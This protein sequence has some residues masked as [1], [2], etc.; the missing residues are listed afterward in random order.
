MKG[1]VTS[2]DGASRYLIAWELLAA[3]LLFF[4]C[5]PTAAWAQSRCPPLDRVPAP[6]PILTSPEATLVPD[7]VCIPF[8]F[9][10]GF[11]GYGNGNPIAYFDQYSWRAFIALVWPSKN[12]SR[13]IPDPSQPLETVRSPG[14]AGETTPP[15]FETFKADWETFQPGGAGPS[16]W[17]SYEFVLTNHHEGCPLAKPGDFLLAP[18]NK[19][20]PTG[21]IKQAGLD[22]TT[23]VLVSRNGKFVRYQAAYN[24]KQFNKILNDKLF[25]ATNIEKD[26]HF[27]D[28]ALSV[29]SSWIDLTNIPNK[30]RYHKRLAWLPDP[31]NHTCDQV[32]VGLV[33]LHI[34]QKTRTRPQWIW[35]SFEHV[36]NVPPP[37]Y[38]P[39]ASQAQPTTFAFNDGTNARMPHDTPADYI[40]KNVLSAA[41]A[42]A[43][44]NIERLM[45]IN[46][47]NNVLQH[48]V[49]TNQA[50]RSALRAKNSVWQYYQ[51][52][53]TQWP[54]T[55]F[56]PA[57]P[58]IPGYTTPGLGAGHDTSAFTN[59]TLETW[60]QTDINRGCMAC[61]NLVK[62][63]D[64]L[65]SLTINAYTSTMTRS[66]PGLTALKDLLRKKLQQ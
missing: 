43:P 35:S 44:I 10:P 55:P 64:F 14:S 54:T 5:A 33:G 12:G 39:P 60:P 45:P 40:F 1:I 6:A 23:S 7:D 58:G 4:A 66:S 63:N 8:Q 42:P 21:N 3:T 38:V 31:F 22:E 50:W 13:G 19:F 48:T 29:K 53:M 41:R 15:V 2:S 62:N 47:D 57:T 52:V 49:A 59:T 32:T 56:S 20:G 46:N 26:V 18:V 65:W 30:E 37:G 27:D 34:V 9:R 16:E 51:L 36:D 25:L 11:P 17:S 61:H 28:N 24:E